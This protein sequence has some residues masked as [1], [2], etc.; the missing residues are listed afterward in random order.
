MNLG[1]KQAEFKNPIK[2]YLNVTTGEREYEEMLWRKLGLGKESLPKERHEVILKS[3]YIPVYNSGSYKY[4]L[5]LRL[6]SD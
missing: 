5:D 2:F 6:L 1:F 4:I 3:G